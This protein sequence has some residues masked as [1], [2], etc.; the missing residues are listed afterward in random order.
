MSRSSSTKVLAAAA[1]LSLIVAV[2]ALAAPLEDPIPERIRTHGG[3][4]SVV[5]VAD[6]LT[7]PNW[8]VTPPG[9]DGEL[10]VVDQTGHLVVVATDDGSTRDALDVSGRLVSLGIG[11]PGT[12]D[13]R[14]FLG[15][16]FAPDFATS[17]LL[18]TYTSEPVDG[19]ADFSTI[20]EGSNAN[21]QAVV[22]EWQ[23]PAPGAADAMV[24]P[25]S[26]RELLRV[27][28]P[29]FNHNA[30]ALVTTADGLLHV[31]FG[32]GGGADDQGTG[33]VPGGNGQDPT[34]PLGSILRID[35][36]GTNSANGQYGIP[37]D[38][39]FVGDASA[40]AETW[41][42]GF[43]NPFRIS[44][45]TATGD[46]WAGDVGQNDIEE[47]DLVMPGGNHG[48]PVKEGSFAFDM[49]G[50]DRGFV[51]DDDPGVPGLV[52]PVVEYDHDEGVSVI[53]G[54][55]YH[56]DDLPQFEGRYIFGEHR[57]P[58]TAAGRLFEIRPNGRLGELRLQGTNALAG[59]R[60]LGFGQDA[61]GEVYVMANATGTPSGE[62]G[63]VLRLAPI[64][65]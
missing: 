46:L 12:F 52:D 49:N 13:E 57:S 62:T 9:R 54:F 42:F 21:H 44:I 55:V 56:G 41:A 32:D 64:H 14:G 2:P 7:A 36:D 22:A 26:R 10:W 29:Q 27:D 28:E 58:D 37:A 65:G 24:D 11:G 47:V 18:Y 60:L 6:G 61:E 51:T 30:G 25:A 31:A 40:I 38:N 19:P 4:V 3:P 35:P 43:R 33:H 63:V 1:T 15:L 23:V 16:A 45:D 8:G 50:T 34:S 59:L 39:P 5:G 20:P 53:G 17:G 48:W